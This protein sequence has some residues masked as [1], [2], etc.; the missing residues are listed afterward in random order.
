[1]SQPFIQLHH[2]VSYPNTVLILC[3]HGNSLLLLLMTKQTGPLLTDAACVDE[4]VS[5]IAAGAHS[6]TSFSYSHFV[7]AA[8]QAGQAAGQNVRTG[9]G[10]SCPTGPDPGGRDRQAAKTNRPVASAEQRSPYYNRM[11]HQDVTSRRV[12]TG[13][14]YRVNCRAVVQPSRFHT[15]TSVEGLYMSSEIL[16]NNTWKPCASAIRSQRNWTWVGCH[17][18]S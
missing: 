17:T 2:C 8:G 10:S 7:Q 16:H 13:C 1:M 14:L 3:C 4:R 11:W 5:P 6:L 9:S 15:N 12:A 18:L